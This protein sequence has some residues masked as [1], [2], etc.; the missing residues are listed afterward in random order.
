MHRT[1]GMPHNASSFD[2]YLSKTVGKSN[3][4]DH[5]ENLPSFPCQSQQSFFFPSAL[6]INKVESTW[7]L[8]FDILVSTNSQIREDE[9]CWDELVRKNINL[10]SFWVSL[11]AVIK[12]SSWYCSRL[13]L[14]PARAK[15]KKKKSKQNKQTIQTNKQHGTGIYTRWNKAIKSHVTRDMPD[16]FA[17]TAK[18]NCDVSLVF[19][20]HWH[21]NYQI[22]VSPSG[23]ATK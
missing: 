11:W 10:G 3:I 4:S 21:I 5:D 20:L 6:L 13:Q 22:S 12:V 18:M 17:T 15:Q 8:W 14:S 2:L 1:N 16:D 19:M 9:L 7:C 23:E